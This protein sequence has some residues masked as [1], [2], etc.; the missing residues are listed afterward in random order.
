M[1]RKFKNNSKL[2][3]I[4]IAI[5]MALMVTLARADFLEDSWR[6]LKP[7]Q[8]PT[9]TESVVEIVP[10]NEVFSN[11]E[12]G[13]IDLRIIETTSSREIPYKL[14]VDRGAKK[15]IPISSTVRD[16]YHLE[17]RY[18]SFVV[19]T[20]SVNLLHNEVE[21]KTRS[22]NFQRRVLIEGSNDIE[23]WATLVEGPKIF[24]FSIG[25]GKFTTRDTRIR[26]PISSSRYIRVRIFDN[27]GIPLDISGAEVFSTVGPISKELEHPVTIKENTE[28]TSK[29]RSQLTLDLGYPGIPVYRLSIVTKQENFHRQVFLEGSDDSKSW[30]EIRLLDNPKVNVGKVISNQ[31]TLFSYDTAR[32]TG[33]KIDFSFTES[34]FRYY[35]LTVMN[36]DNPALAIDDINAHGFLR[37]L[38]FPVT[39][40]ENYSLYYGN[41]RST[42]ASYDLFPYRVADSLPRAELGAH[43]P[44][45]NFKDSHGPIIERYPW[46]LPSIIALAILLIVAFLGY[47]FHQVRDR[48]PPPT[49]TRMP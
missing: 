20:G 27:D 38:I 29:K 13:L 37:R 1:A 6:Y 28:N 18:T 45:P 17:D 46:I 30:G 5:G 15:N 42:V 10:D 22:T 41:E 48:L 8:I 9:G 49:G 3:V 47:V 7:I 23:E 14:L 44:N 39:P 33:Q 32:F 26:Y 31:G 2:A 12:A 36:E 40:G 11:S 16:L 19:D 24:D 35:R 43:L 34:T 25:E 4:I 21:V